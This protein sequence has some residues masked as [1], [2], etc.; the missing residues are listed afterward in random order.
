MEAALRHI[1]VLDSK[2]FYTDVGLLYEAADLFFF[3][4]C[5]LLHLLF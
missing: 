4:F 3:F 1:E 5:R 2:T